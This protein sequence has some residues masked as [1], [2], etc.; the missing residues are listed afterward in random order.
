MSATISSL[1]KHTYQWHEYSSPEK[2]IECC[3]ELRATRFRQEMK[4]I[5]HYIE[6]KTSSQTEIEKA[7]Q[8]Q[9]QRVAF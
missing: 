8:K 2:Y 4:P 7:P 1:H 3:L 6:A 9:M 5:S